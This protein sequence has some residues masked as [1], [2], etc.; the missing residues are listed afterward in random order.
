MSQ[1]RNEQPVSSKAPSPALGA[2]PLCAAAPPDGR[3]ALLFRSQ[4]PLHVANILR[5]IEPLARLSADHFTRTVLFLDLGTPTPRHACGL[6]DAAVERLACL[7]ATAPYQIARASAAPAVARLAA[8]VAATLG[9]EEGQAAADSRAWFRDIVLAAGLV[10]TRATHAAVESADLTG[11]PPNPGPAPSLSPLNRRTDA[12]ADLILA[13]KLASRLDRVLPGSCPF[14]IPLLTGCNAFQALDGSG[15][16][17][18]SPKG[19]LYLGDSPDAIRKK[20][21]QARTDAA[22][23]LDPESEMSADVSNLILLLHA[24]SGEPAVEILD[25]FAGKGYVRL[26]DALADAAIGF[27]APIRA[28]REELLAAGSDLTTAVREGSAA[29]DRSAAEMADAI[30]LAPQVLAA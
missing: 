10:A 2:V 28:R 17:G 24:L 21:R 8:I 25:R 13:R 16:M 20:V 15:P 5:L 22:T 11:S 26:K 1:S 19:T 3:A 12:A 14:P 4:E 9:P 30:T 7:P 23:H 18:L 27:L 29:L 6:T